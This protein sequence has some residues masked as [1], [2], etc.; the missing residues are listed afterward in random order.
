MKHVVSCPECHVDPIAHCPNVDDARQ[1]ASRH[2]N[3]QG[4]ECHIA[5]ILDT[6]LEGLL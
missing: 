1:I 5:T 2:R 4:H 3:L 6:P